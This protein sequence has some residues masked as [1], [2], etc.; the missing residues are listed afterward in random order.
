MRIGTISI[1]IL[2]ASLASA[3]SCLAQDR[4]LFNI[5]PDTTYRSASA[6]VLVNGGGSFRSNALDNLFMRKLVLG[7]TIGKDIKKNVEGTLRDVNRAGGSGQAGVQAY[8]F[9]SFGKKANWGWTVGASAHVDMG[10][11]FPEDLYRIVFEGNAEF[12][13]QEMQFDRLRSEYMLWEKISV[14]LFDK[15]TMSEVSLSLVGGSDFYRA[16]VDR[17]SLY[18]SQLGDTLVLDY[19]GDFMLSAPDGSFPAIKGVGAALDARINLP[20]ADEKG[21]IRIQVANLGFVNWNSGTEHYQADSTWT[22]QGIEV[23]DLVGEDILNVDIP[24]FEDS[25]SYTQT[26]GSALTMLPGTIGLSVVRMQTN[27]DYLE[28]GV[29][30]KTTGM[31]HPLV[32]G[33]YHYLLDKSTS[34]FGRVSVGGYGRLR[35]GAGVE[36]YWRDWYVSVQTGDLPGLILNDLKGR[37][38]WFT[39]GRFM[40]TS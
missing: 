36:K 34:V 16:E 6:A 17:A 22:F 19:A 5:M 31:S 21:F 1:V 12:A 38:A 20:M 14:G 30:V 26:A 15:R 29:Q 27:T 4:L 8:L 13:G 23:N 28:F 11:T 3:F 39:L 9:D 37:G 10:L 40:K 2:V 32:Y 7:G 25:L 33:S 18:T 24:T 35:V